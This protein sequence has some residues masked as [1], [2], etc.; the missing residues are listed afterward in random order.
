MVTSICLFRLYFKI[1]VKEERYRER[2]ELA[3]AW[4]LLDPLANGNTFLL[5]LHHRSRVPLMTT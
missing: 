1:T 5:I 2:E 4:N 3:K